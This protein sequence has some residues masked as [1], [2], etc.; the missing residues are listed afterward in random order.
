MLLRRAVPVEA[1]VVRTHSKRSISEALTDQGH[2][3]GCAFAEKPNGITSSRGQLIGLCSKEVLGGEGARGAAC[4]A[5]ATY[6]IP[7]KQGRSRA[8][9]LLCVRTEA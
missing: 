9:G 7:A 2:T 8:V 1:E 4:R 5:N 3:G 6:K